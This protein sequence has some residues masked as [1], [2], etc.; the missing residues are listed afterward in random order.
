MGMTRR[1]FMFLATVLVSLNA[2]FWLAAGG[3]ALPKAVINEFFGNRMIRAEVL[4]QG[5]SGPLDYRIDR[6]VISAVSGTSITLREADGTS[7]TIPIASAARLVGPARFRTADQLKP[8][9]R[10]VVYR[11]ANAPA[12][13]IQVEGRGALP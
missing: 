12:E 4:V 11:P 6:G 10:V 8:R 9:L 2:F 1:R 7:V 13:L 3:L 5:A